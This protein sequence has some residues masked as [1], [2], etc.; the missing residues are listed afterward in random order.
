MQAD[1]DEC[2]EIDDIAHRPLQLFALMQ[3]AE[4]QHA[5]LE[6][7]LRIAV[8]VI[9]G[10]GGDGIQDI[11]DRIRVAAQRFAQLP[12]IGLHRLFPGSCRAHVRFRQIQLCQHLAGQGI[13]FRMDGRRIHAFLSIAHTQKARSLFIRAL[14]DAR[15]LLDLPARADHAV[16]LPVSDDIAGADGIEARD[17]PKQ[18]RRRCIDVH[19]DAVD[20]FADGKIGA[21]PSAVSG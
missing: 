14:S 20:H 4:L 5:A 10:R 17:M 21:V 7:C 2:A 8:A 13:A 1:V 6:Q 19:P 15:H 3:I 9:S 12:R 18:L 16:L 11:L